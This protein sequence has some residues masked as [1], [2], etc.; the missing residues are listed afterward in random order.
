VIAFG[1]GGVLETVRGLNQVSPT[2]VFYEQ[3]T[4]TALMDAVNSFEQKMET[5]FPANCRDNALRFS[6][7]RFRSEFSLFVEQKWARFKS[8]T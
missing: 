8:N 1:K 7:D 4:T 6:V 5:I 2:G 3:Q